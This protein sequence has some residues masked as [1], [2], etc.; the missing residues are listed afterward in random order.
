MSTIS[1]AGA[2]ALGASQAQ[3]KAKVAAKMLK[4]THG[5]EEN[6]AKMIKEA[7]EQIEAVARET[8]KGAPPVGMGGRVDLTV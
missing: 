5:Q 6:V 7:G 3:F 1:D 4:H 2:A 8:A